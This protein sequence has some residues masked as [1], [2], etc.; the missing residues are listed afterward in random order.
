MLHSRR[1]FLKLSLSLA[2]GALLAACGAQ[3]E[4]AVPTAETRPGAAPS[5]PAQ[6][7]LPPPSPTQ[8]DKGQ[9]QPR[10]QAAGILVIGAGMAGIS[11]A[12]ALKKAGRQVIV[13]E[14]RSRTGGRV[15]TSRA[16]PDTPLDLGGSWIHG[17]RGNPL[18]DLAKLAGASTLPTDYDNGL[19]YEADGSELS[20]RQYKKLETYG[21]EVLWECTDLEEK[22]AKDYSVQQAID[23]YIAGEGLS[24]DERRYL[25][26]YVNTTLEHEIAADANE[27][28]AQYTDDTEEFPGGDVL[29]PNGYGQLVDYLAGGLDIRLGHNVQKIAYTGRGVTVSTEQGEF[30]GEYALVTLPI[31]VLKKGNVAFT[32]GL[33]EEKREAI[34][35]LGSG[36]LNKVYLRFPSAFWPKEPELFNYIG[37]EKGQWAEWYNFYHYLNKPVLMGFNAGSYARLLEQKSDQEI[38]TGAMRVLRTIYGKNIPEPQAWQIT[39]WASDPFALGSYSFNGIGASVEMRKLLAKPVEDRLFFAGEATER[40]YPATVHGAYLSG[41]REAQRILKM[42]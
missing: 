18:T 5:Q 16:W 3:P 35:S 42:G 21:D 34:H 40:D 27:L 25:D 38:V 6:T 32:P 19:V 15:W 14:G 9:Q 26:F 12:N 31:G 1:D 8:Q 7:S 33:P 28:S 41:L 10:S 13:L 23:E 37:M 20:D 24:D 4:P 36:L 17:Q 22:G 29:F 2:A 11:A 39:R 30:S